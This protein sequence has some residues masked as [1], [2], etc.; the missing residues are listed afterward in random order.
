MWTVPGDTR[1][2]G[3]GKEAREIQESG[4]E[5]DQARREGLANFVAPAI[6]P[7]RIHLSQ[8]KLRPARQAS[9]GTI[10]TCQ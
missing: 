10:D 7:A 9:P 4:Q 5:N 1:R 6:N 2:N 8:D 3:H